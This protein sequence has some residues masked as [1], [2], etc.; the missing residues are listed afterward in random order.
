MGNIFHSYIFYG[1]EGV[2][3]KTLARFL[4]NLIFCTGDQ[5]PCGS[6]DGCKKFILK[7][8]VDY[9]EIGNIHESEKQSFNIDKVRAMI[10]EVFIKPNEGKYKIF[11][12]Y[13][14]DRLLLNSANALLK[15]LEEPPPNT[16][17]LLTADNIHSVMPTIVSRCVKFFV[18]PVERN[19]CL[20]F[21]KKYNIKDN[22][23]LNDIVSLSGGSLGRAKFYLTQEGLNVLN[24][25]KHLFMAY[26]N[27]NELE[28]VEVLQKIE[29][30]MQQTLL[31]LD[32]FLDRLLDLIN[33]NVSKNS[34]TK[35]KVQ[36]ISRLVNSVEKAAYALKRGG[37]ISVTL[38][39]FGCECFDKI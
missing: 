17:F 38:A 18:R 16:I 36:Y 32:C 4:A 12:L 15:I 13:N 14:V 39:R 28:F 37:N 19:C 33:T 30:D 21:L 10:D 24:L 9:F 26:I 25:S 6:C 3:K 8:N 5:K 27:K 1:K 11:L 23:I 35:A 34:K 29:T 2:G 20:E 7:C 31:V 22:D